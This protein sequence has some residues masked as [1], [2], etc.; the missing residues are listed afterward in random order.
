MGN[1]GSHGK[2][3]EN[4]HGSWYYHALKSWVGG[5][6]RFKITPQKSN[7]D[8]YISTIST[9]IQWSGG[10]YSEL[11]LYPYSVWATKGASWSHE[12]T[13]LAAWWI[14]ITLFIIIYHHISSLSIFHNQIFVMMLMMLMTFI[15]MWMSMLSLLPVLQPN[16]GNEDMLVQFM[17]D[18]GRSSA[19]S[20]TSMRACTLASWSWSIIRCR[21]F[22]TFSCTTKA[23][24]GF[25]AIGSMPCH[26]SLS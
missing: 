20:H 2:P 11:W 13:F 10:N 26:V 17:Q 3:K 19:C 14:I 23:F 15:S 18:M 16:I 5:I 25:S 9:T 1:W 4:A 24:G 21:P 12:L 7:F 8:D 22:F 6:Y